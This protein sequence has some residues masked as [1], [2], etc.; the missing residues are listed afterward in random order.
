MSVPLPRAL[1]GSQ[2]VRMLLQCVFLVYPV[3]SCPLSLNSS[4]ASLATQSLCTLL[5]E[6]SIEMI[7]LLHP[8]LRGREVLADSRATRVDVNLHV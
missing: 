5:E 1:A 2:S 3:H 6:G 4:A 8:G 7:S